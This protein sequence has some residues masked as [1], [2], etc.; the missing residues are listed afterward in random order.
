MSF[1]RRRAGDEGASSDPEA[2]LAALARRRDPDAW[3]RIYEEQYPTVYGFLRIRLGDP[4]EAEE[5]ASQVFELAFARADR[6]E[7]RG[8]SIGAWLIGIARNLLRDHR[9]RRRRRGD[10]VSLEAPLAGASGEL[11]AAALRVDLQAALEHLTPDQQLVLF[12]RFI[13][14]RSIADT[15]RMMQR[16]EEAVKTLQR[17][18]LAAM[19]RRLREGGSGAVP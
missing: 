11:E 5:L 14:D 12:L 18:A 17:R 2:A 16:S 4:A 3:S 1:F 8:V 13:E 19:A 7:Y 9:K 15:A 6:F 10:P